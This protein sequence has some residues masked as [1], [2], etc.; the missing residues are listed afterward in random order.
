MHY[1]QAVHV[2]AWLLPP[3]GEVLFI[4]VLRWWDSR[5]K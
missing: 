1:I 4:L 5:N 3:P 2:L